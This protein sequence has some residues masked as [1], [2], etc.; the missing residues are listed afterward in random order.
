MD[1]SLGIIVTQCLLA[2]SQ[3]GRIVGNVWY[4]SGCKMYAITNVK[5]KYE[6]SPIKVMT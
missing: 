1:W 4:Q 5:E 6:I 3:S 2:K